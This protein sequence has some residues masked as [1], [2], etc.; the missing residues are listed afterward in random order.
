[1]KLITVRELRNHPGRVWKELEHEDLVVTANGKPVG[2]LLGVGEHDLE[3]A[4]A[5][6]RRARALLVVSKMRRR[7]AE[8]GLT[9]L[10]ARELDAEVRAV[11]RGRRR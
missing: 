7:A 4:L 9:K 3:Q 10:T 6:V 8:Q 1:M 5:A 2:I 11:R